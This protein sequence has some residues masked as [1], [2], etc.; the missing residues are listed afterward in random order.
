MFLLGNEAFTFHVK[1]SY[2]DQIDRELEQIAEVLLMYHWGKSNNLQL[3]YA[4]LQMG[5]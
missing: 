5:G 3:S 2:S 4:M 1:S